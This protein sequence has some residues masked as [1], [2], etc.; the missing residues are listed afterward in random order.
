MQTKNKVR[1]II[2]HGGGEYLKGCAELDAVVTN[3]IITA[4]G[5]PEDNGRAERMN[6]TIKNAVSTKLTHL[7]AP[8]HPYSESFYAVCKAKHCVPRLGHSTTPQ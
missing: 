4:Y 2:L 8:T 5:T 1:K 6:R 7:G 3:I